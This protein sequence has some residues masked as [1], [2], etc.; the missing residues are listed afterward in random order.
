MIRVLDGTNPQPLPM[1]RPPAVEPRVAQRQSG[2]DRLGAAIDRAVDQVQRDLR[3]AEQE[4][5]NVLNRV[6]NGI[7]GRNN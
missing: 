1:Y 2:Q 5:E 3:E 6:L 7:F 4:A